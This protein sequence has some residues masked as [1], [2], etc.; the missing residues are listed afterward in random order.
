MAW[1][2]EGGG[3]G[4]GVK[5][6]DGENQRGRSEWSSGFVCQ[7]VFCGG[8]SHIS[9]FTDQ[10]KSLHEICLLAEHIKANVI[11]S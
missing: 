9:A 4:G 6:V 10:I 1:M 5:G 8:S 11:L 2:G 7:V 3:G